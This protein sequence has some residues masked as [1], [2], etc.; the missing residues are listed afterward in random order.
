VL[1]LG[2]VALFL[3]ARP[4]IAAAVQARTA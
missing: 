2:A 3:R 4:G 1:T